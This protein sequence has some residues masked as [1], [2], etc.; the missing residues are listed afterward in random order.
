MWKSEDSSR[1]SVL[2]FCHMGPRNQSQGQ[3]P[4]PTGPHHQYFQSFRV[5]EVRDQRATRFNI[6]S[7][8]PP[9]FIDGSFC[10]LT[11]GWRSMQGALQMPL[12]R[13][14]HPFT[15]PPPSSPPRFLARARRAEFSYELSRTPAFNLQQGVGLHRVGVG[16]DGCH[17]SYEN[18]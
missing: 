7:G 2:S 1:K 6:W 3:V 5:C 11:C 8:L 4:F 16:A 17:K 9:C 18:K 10:V 13:G 14:T 15:G 12:Y